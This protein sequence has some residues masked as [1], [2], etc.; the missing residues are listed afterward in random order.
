[1]S[2][3]VTHPVV[4]CDFHV[5]GH[6]WSA[7]YHTGRDYAAAVGTP[8][9]AT[10]AGTVVAV[11]SDRSYGTSVTVDSGGVHH[12]YAHLSSAQVRRGQAVAAGQRLGL[13]GA[14]GNAFGPHLHYEERV[15][16]FAYMNHRRPEFDVATSLLSPARPGQPG[17]PGQPA[18]GTTAVWWQR[19]TYGTRD[20]DS[21]R[22]LQRRLN[23][24][25]AHLPVTGAYLDLTRDA[26]R[27]FQQRQ[28]WKGA[29]ADGLLYVPSR[30]SS[31]QVSVRRLFPTPPYDVHWERP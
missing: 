7:G 12:L 21:V 11:G 6:H 18:A 2:A 17:Q 1:M 3:P 14:T 27:A 26:V 4:T 22:A 8:V 19:L 31:G 23:A 29:D 10:R 5:P 24:L 9:R 28:G 25:G 13:S 30:R 15:S 20:S 16:P